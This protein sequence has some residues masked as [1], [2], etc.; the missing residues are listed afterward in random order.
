MKRPILY[1]AV[2]VLFASV[3]FAGHEEVSLAKPWNGYWWP[4]FEGALATGVG[5]REHPST[6]E[7]YD[8]RFGLD[9]KATD[10]ELA[11]HHKPD[12][13]AWN[14]HCNGW[15]AAA[16][17]EVEPTETINSNGYTF[18]I[19]DLKGLWTMYYQG[20]TGTIYRG[21]DG[22]SL[23][24]LTFQTELQAHLRDNGIPLLMDSD[25]T[26]EVW[27][28]PIYDY[29]MDWTDDGN[30][31]HV[32]LTVWTSTDGVSPDEVS[33][34]RKEFNY[35]YDLTLEGGEP[36]SGEW[37]GYSITYHPDFCRYPEEVPPDNPSGNPYV[38]QDNVT[39]LAQGS[40][41][42][43]ADDGDEPNDTFDDA[44][45]M[46]GGFIG[47]ILDE[48]WFS[49]P[50]EPEEKFSLSL[51]CNSRVSNSTSPPFFAQLFDGA[52]SYLEDVGFEQATRYPNTTLT[53]TDFISEY[54]KIAPLLN[55][56][57]NEN[58]QF[59]VE[60]KSYTSVIHHTI[61]GETFWE[62][63]VVAGFWPVT[64]SKSIRTESHYRVIGVTQGAGF[65]LDPGFETISGMTFRDVPLSGGNGTPEWI[66]LNSLT[67]EYPVYSF[68]LSQGEGSMSFMRA[69]QPDTELILSH[70]PPQ[71]A[72]WWY[73]M[74]LVNSSRFYKA[75]VE[76]TLYGENGAE[77][78]V[79]PIRLDPYQKKVGLFEEF[80][81]GVSQ[82]DVSYI[83]FKSNEPINAS[84]LYGTLDHKELSY[85][86]AAG[87]FGWIAPATAEHAGE[88]E[89][90][91]FIPYNLLNYG[92]AGWSGV[93]FV[94]PDDAAVS[95]ILNFKWI[96]DDN[97][98]AISD[99]W[100][101]KHHKWVGVME[102]L[103]P[104]GVD[105]THLVRIGVT[106]QSG[107]VTG[108]YMTGGHNKGTLISFPFLKYFGTVDELFPFIQRDGLETIPVYYNQKPYALTGLPVYAYDI[109]GLQVGTTKRVDLN[110]FELKKLDLKSL[111][112]PEE[113]ATITSVELYTNKFVVPYVIY[114]DP[115]EVYCA[116][117]PPTLTHGTQ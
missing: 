79:V 6:L 50:I 35:T 12:G 95:A 17:S 111:F 82:A 19:G 13:A 25:P 31:R 55:H 45:P 15:S 75:A 37:T 99:L 69:E 116:I 2:I 109:N 18:Y 58:Y 102:D 30:T 115:D 27:T 113:L 60:M 39:L 53:G 7:K 62:N 74:V 90:S 117:V 108:F 94:T 24:P 9:G 52:G 64:D 48:D 65:A 33:S 110:A 84:A 88:D 83:R 20:A 8:S 3:V 16:V 76:A 91:F 46:E 77:L 11:N 1:A 34:D 38:N 107:P 105:L 40:Y 93:V 51:Y 61:P 92:A 106:V 59:G 103:V 42:S 114:E 32:T 89:Q 41:N 26:E 112:T 101:G 86:P 47:R 43:S 68:Y 66:K 10:W 96:M 80:F 49:L 21:T 23:D 29:S 44:V 56:F 78:A 28:W 85:V 98:F 54:L 70:V 71:V 67:D 5:Y 100:I 57:Y 104:D 36:V 14:G 73:G 72:Y 63:F 4:M 81:P 87:R 22:G 97:S